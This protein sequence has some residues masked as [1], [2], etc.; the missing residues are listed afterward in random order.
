ML[1]RFYLPQSGQ[2]LF[3]GKDITGIDL[4]SVRNFIG[5]VG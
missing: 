4:K 3:D 1:E 5:Y 2:I